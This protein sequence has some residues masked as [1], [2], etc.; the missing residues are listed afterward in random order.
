MRGS[1]SSN[2][3]D[4]RSH[5]CGTV[6]VV[7]TNS[8]WSRLLNGLCR[9]R[10]PPALF[11]W[12]E[13]TMS[14]QQTS[15]AFN[16]VL[17]MMTSRPAACSDQSPRCEYRDCGTSSR[18][19]ACVRV[20]CPKEQ[21]DLTI[22]ATEGIVLVVASKSWD[23]GFWMDLVGIVGLQFGRAAT[24]FDELSTEEQSLCCGFGV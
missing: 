24:A 4:G 22:T 23:R 10:S 8:V 21:S 6:V 3:S 19:H 9:Y 1:C 12:P 18:L 11:V 7:A 17:Y 20:V 15:N 2:R 14:L 13:R 16:C 5:W